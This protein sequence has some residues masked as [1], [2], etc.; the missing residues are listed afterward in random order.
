[1]KIDNTKNNNI[2]IFVFGTLRKGERL[3]FYMDTENYKGLHYTKGQLMKAENGSVY[4]DFSNPKAV[5]IGE[6]YEVNFACLQRINH[7]E[8]VSGEF[9]KGYDLAVLPIWKLNENKGYIFSKKCET[10]AFFYQRRNRPFRI[11]NGDYITDFE[12]IKTIGGFLKESEDKK[13]SSK[14]VLIFY[15][16][17]LK[18]INF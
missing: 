10:N 5:T 3:E 16:E 6:L 14:E 12:P 18:N 13:L 17:K 7:L 4:I 11:I 1:M 15:K 8:A 2:R 9:P